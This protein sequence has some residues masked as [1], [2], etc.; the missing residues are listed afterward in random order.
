MAPHRFH[1]SLLVSARPE[2][3]NASERPAGTPRPQRETNTSYP[4]FQVSSESVQIDLKV[5]TLIA[6]CTR[7]QD[8]PGQDMTGHPGVPSP[9]PEGP[10]CCPGGTGQAEGQL[11]ATASSATR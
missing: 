6:R 10:G 9:S 3:W 8:H 11:G 4:S 7:N 1:K 5:A 2:T